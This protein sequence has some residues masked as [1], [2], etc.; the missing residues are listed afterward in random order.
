MWFLVFMYY[1]E[2]GIG[3]NVC[4]GNWNSKVVNKW[5]IKDKTLCML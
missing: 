3:L 5:N 2:Y 1:V 4:V